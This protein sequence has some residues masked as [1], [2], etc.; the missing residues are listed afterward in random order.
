M[1]IMGHKLEGS[2]VEGIFEPSAAKLHSDEGEFS[3]Q[4]VRVASKPSI[5]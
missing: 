2:G 4:T 5:P 1:K 3:H